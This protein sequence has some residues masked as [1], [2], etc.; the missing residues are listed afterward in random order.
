MGA[1]LLCDGNQ[2]E[3]EEEEDVDDDDVSDDNNPEKETV[4]G[5]NRRINDEEMKS[6]AIEDKLESKET[7]KT[8]KKAEKI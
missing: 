8:Q 4:G 5:Y 2:L 6:Q 7:W 1:G 3:E